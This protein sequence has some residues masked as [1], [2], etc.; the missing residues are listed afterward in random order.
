MFEGQEKVPTE[1]LAAIGEVTVTWNSLEGLLHLCLIKLLG[2]E[3]TDGR[4]HAVFAHMNFPQRLDVLGALIGEVIDV[5]SSHP[6]GAYKN[7]IYPLL[8]DAQNRRNIISHSI[9]GVEGGKVHISSVSARG[10][11]KVKQQPITLAEVQVASAAIKKA[12]LELFMAVVVGS[13][14][15]ATPQ[16]GQ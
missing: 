10:S 3:L 14:P 12:G 2:K 1:Y 11:V 8:K 5:S 7:K 13:D 6:L 4:S 9:W 16:D 15:S